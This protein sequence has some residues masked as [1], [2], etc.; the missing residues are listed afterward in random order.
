MEY[1]QEEASDSHNSS[2]STTPYSP[3][4]PCRIHS[5]WKV[6]SNADP[7]SYQET[8][9]TYSTGFIQV[10]K[11]KT[12]PPLGDANVGMEPDYYIYVEQS[13]PYN[14]TT[15]SSMRSS[16]IESYNGIIARQERPFE[17][18]PILGVSNT[19]NNSYM[20]EQ[21]EAL[22]R[23]FSCNPCYDIRRETESANELGLTEMHIEAWVLMKRFTPL[24][25][26]V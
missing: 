26:L 4:Q 15:Y 7:E 23:G 24:R 1:T 2:R 25:N 9:Q 21:L 11:S 17:H 18:S 14:P 5:N 12:T 10:S 8:I 22:E 13:N 19:K 20:D 3:S 16:P 6:S